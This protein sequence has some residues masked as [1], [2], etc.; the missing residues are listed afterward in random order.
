M[1]AGTAPRR[2]LEGP[3]WAILLEVREDRK[4]RTL[5]RRIVSFRQVGKTY[6]RSEET[7]RLHLYTAADLVAELTRAGFE[8]RILDG[9]GRFRFASAHAAFIAVKP[10]PPQG[11]A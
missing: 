3:D 2:F 7:H 9:Y 1:T 5:T 10:S 11:D 4:R 8:A 6:R